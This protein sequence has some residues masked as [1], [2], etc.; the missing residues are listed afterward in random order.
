MNSIKTILSSISH[1]P[2]PLP[3]GSWSYYQEWNQVL[4][5]HWKVPY[6]DL[7]NLLPQKLTLDTF[8]G[9]CYISLVAFSMCR[10]RPKYFPAIPLISN[11]HEI[12]LRTYI[13]NDNKPGV[14]FLN[15]EAEKS[16][17][18]FIAKLLS[19]L[20]YEKADIHR[21]GNVFVSNNASKV[22]SLDTTY[23]VSEK[24][25]HKSAL[26][27]WLTE[28]YSLYLDL[29]HHCYRYDIHHEEWPLSE[30]ETIHLNLNYNLGKIILTD[31]RPDLAHYSDGVKVISWSRQPA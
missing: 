6:E 5:L 3:T 22:T 11:F 26:D 14:Y 4:F 20:P 29:Q 30:V 2:Y 12:N 19:G 24:I 13:L 7:R 31:L 28:R 9:A 16:I 10:I 23:T 17:S 18:V 1:R 15:I 21:T 25:K 8:D 27:R